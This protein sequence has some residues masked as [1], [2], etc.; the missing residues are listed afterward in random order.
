MIEKNIRKEVY[1]TQKEKLKKYV[2]KKWDNHELKNYHFLSAN[3]SQCLP[4]FPKEKHKSFYHNILS[5]RALQGIDTHF[6]NSFNSIKGVDTVSKKIEQQK[7][8]G[9][10]VSFHLGSFRSAMA[11]LIQANLDV[12]LII[13]PLPYRIQKNDIINQYEKIKEFF[14]SNSN[15]IIYPADKK[16]LSIQILLKTKQNYSVLAFI[17]GNTGMNGAFNQNNSVTAKF[18][19]RKVFFRKGLAMLSYYTKCPLIPILSYYDDE[20]YP[21]WEIIDPITPNLELSVQE[22]AKTATIKIVKILEEALK[23]YPDQWE[24]W[25]YLHKFLD[26]EI[27]N[28]RE[29][30]ESEINTN[31]LKINPNIGLFAYDEKFY[32]LNKDTYAIVELTHNIFIKLDHNR[33]F[34]VEKEDVGNI[35]LLIKKDIL[36][37]NSVENESA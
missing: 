26:I 2:D 11:F 37:L 27:T 20:D 25:L 9:I 14:N 30:L 33:F 35:I 12:V 10:F 6:Y 18:L 8:P 32:V 5:Y 24:G 3:L 16:D 13:D 1:H 34:D 36:Y 19:G 29:V 4:N 22:Y 23:L 15:L 17:D 7:L 28:E 21:H 31:T